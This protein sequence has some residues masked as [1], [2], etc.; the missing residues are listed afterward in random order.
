MQSGSQNYVQMD[1]SVS[2]SQLRPP[3]RLAL[4]IG[5]RK[6]RARKLSSYSDSDLRSFSRF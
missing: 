5:Q 1:G 2:G 6:S 3:P 4:S